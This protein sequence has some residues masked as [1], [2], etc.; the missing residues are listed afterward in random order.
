MPVHQCGLQL[1]IACESLRCRHT[2]REQA[3]VDPAC[4]RLLPSDKPGK[5]KAQG[6]T[7]ALQQ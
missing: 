4:F 7:A 3:G 1:L 5:G 6:P 2:K